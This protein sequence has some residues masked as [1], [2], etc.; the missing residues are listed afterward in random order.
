MRGNAEFN[1]IMVN[2][3]VLRYVMA[4]AQFCGGERIIAE[5]ASEAKALESQYHTRGVPPQESQLILD[6]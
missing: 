3:V 6:L 2:Q 4:T 1:C 5:L